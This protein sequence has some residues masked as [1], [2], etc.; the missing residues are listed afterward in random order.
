MTR[1]SELVTTL[2]RLIEAG[3]ILEAMKRF[4]ADDVTMLNATRQE[5]N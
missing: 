2:T 3:Q 5:S 4:Y 1:L